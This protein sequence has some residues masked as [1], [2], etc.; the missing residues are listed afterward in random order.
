MPTYDG[1]DNRHAEAGRATTQLGM[2]TL[3]GSHRT[4]LTHVF[5]DRLKLRVGLGA[6]GFHLAADAS[7]PTLQPLGELP[8]PD[9]DPLLLS[10]TI[11]EDFLDLSVFTD[12]DWTVVDG[13]R[14]M[15]GVRADW[16]DYNGTSFFPVDPRLTVRYTPA[17][18]VTV[19]GNVGTYHQPPSLREIDRD[20]GNPDLPP[21][22]SIQS[23]VG[24]EVRF[25]TDWELDVT[26]FYNDMRAIPQPSSDLKPTDGSEV[27]RQNYISGGR[28]RAYGVELML[29]KR[30]GDWVYGWLTY[31]LSRSERRDPDTGRYEPFTFD[32]TH[33]LN[34]AWTFELPYDWSIATRFRLTSGN[35]ALRVVGAEYDA[36]ADSYQPIYRG[37]ERLPLF[38]QLDLRVDK[39]FRLDTWLVSVYL[40]VQNVYYAKNAEFW[41]Y[42]YDFSRR[43]PVTSIPFL[44]TLG[45]RAVF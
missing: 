32:Q 35:P 5:S 26:G 45:L 34:L 19:K 31:T 8:K 28:G 24:A 16:Y 7:V 21:Q 41:R 18:A 9:F 37:T 36:D 44:P 6:L 40:D 38:H 25:A 2:D 42:K 23:S 39:K 33:V 43:V 4:T 17:A 10:G 20:Y 3:G 1:S 12:V 30:F 29:R 14:V 15:P 27:A 11:T 22:W 13:L